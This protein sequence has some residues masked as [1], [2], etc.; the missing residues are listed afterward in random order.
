M[1]DSSPLYLGFDLSTQQLK[2]VAVTSNLK[3]VYNAKFDF[4]ADSRGFHIRKGVLTNDIDHEVYAP[5]SLWLQ[6]LDVL[7]GKLIDH[8]LDLHRVRGISGAG[9]QHGSVYWSAAG[10]HALQNLDVERNLKEQLEYAF[11]HPFSPNWQDAS[12]Q[13]ECEAFDAALGGPQQLADVTGSKAHH[14]RNSHR[15]LSHDLRVTYSGLRGPKFYT[16]NESIQRRTRRHHESLLSPPSL[17]LYFLA[18]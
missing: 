7:L 15:A 3:V 4:D 16:S 18:K 17:P 10:E 2:V 1:T 13:K 11:S 14:V 8:G 6:A 9:Q 5:V 12:T